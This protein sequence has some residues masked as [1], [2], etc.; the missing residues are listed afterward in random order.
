MYVSKKVAVWLIV[1]SIIVCI[2]AFFV[3]NRPHTLKGG[4]YYAFYFFY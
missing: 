2:D 3:L 1:S 4:K